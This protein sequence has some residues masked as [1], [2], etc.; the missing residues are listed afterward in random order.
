ML[1]ALS[2]HDELCTCWTS[3]VFPVQLFAVQ[4]ICDFLCCKDFDC[5]IFAADSK[6]HGLLGH[7]CLWCLVMQAAAFQ[8]GESS[9]DGLTGSYQDSIKAEYM[10]ADGRGADPM[11][12]PAG[13]AYDEQQQ[14]EQINKLLQE[15]QVCTGPFCLLERLLYLHPTYLMEMRLQSCQLTLMT[16]NTSLEALRQV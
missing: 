8:G 3:L 7:V 4:G 6:C 1:R 5:A 14:K 12:Q 11:L 13:Q 15:E 10:T 9:K 16:S 2:A